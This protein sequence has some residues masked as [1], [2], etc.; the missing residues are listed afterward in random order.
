M[1]SYIVLIALACLFISCTR[2]VNGRYQITSI[3]A[4]A[5]GNDTI[6]RYLRKS[7][8]GTAY[9]LAIDTNNAVLISLNTHNRFEFHRKPMYKHPT[10]NTEFH[11][12]EDI[13]TLI[14]KRDTG[15]TL[16]VTLAVPHDRPL[17]IPT[18][19][20]VGF[21]SMFNGDAKLGTVK[22]Y[23]TKVE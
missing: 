9:D 13:F 19:S 20:T 16:E 23:L 6:V 4:N 10:Y 5:S 21:N 12:G 22:C 18:Q 7:L 8:R 1:K 2:S 11:A 15:I 14:L 17:V 3:D